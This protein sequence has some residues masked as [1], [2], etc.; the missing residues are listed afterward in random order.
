MKLWHLTRNDD[1]MNNEAAVFVVR[2]PDEESAR[3]IAVEESAK[4]EIY[5]SDSTN[6]LSPDR[7][8]V[9]LTAD[10]PAGVVCMDFYEP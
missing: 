5:G 8:C 7:P 2:A 10:G 4:V 9:E 3:R 1:V 6:W